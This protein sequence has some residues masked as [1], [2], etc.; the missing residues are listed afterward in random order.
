MHTLCVVTF[1]VHV[2]NKLD[3]RRKDEVFWQLWHVKYCFSKQFWSLESRGLK[4]LKN[5]VSFK[6]HVCIRWSSLRSAIEHANWSLL[7]GYKW[8]WKNLP[9]GSA[10]EKKS[11]I[12]RMTW[13]RVNDE[14]IFFFVYPFKA[15]G[16]PWTT[17]KQASMFQKALTT[18][19][20]HDLDFPSSD[21]W[22]G[23]FG[24]YVKHY[25]CRP[26]HAAL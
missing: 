22:C 8:F 17:N 15:G 12:F 5:N 1:N 13:D 24:Q 26:P 14:R 3:C 19:G 16:P 18:L 7:F 9:L 4:W 20:W 2:H 25:R 23:F 21:C 6:M 11:C 10:E